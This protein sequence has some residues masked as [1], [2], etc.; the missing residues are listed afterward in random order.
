MYNALTLQDASL[1]DIITDEN[2]EW[3]R[4]LTRLTYPKGKIIFQPG[5]RGESLYLLH[6]GYVRVYRLS[7]DGRE[8]TLGLLGKK[9]VLGELALVSGSWQTAFAEVMEDT[10]ISLLPW[11]AFQEMMRRE[12]EVAYRIMVRMSERLHQAEDLIEDLVNRDVASR[13][14]RILLQLAEQF[15]RASQLGIVIDLRLPYQEIANMVGST[16]ETVTRAI[17]H[18]QQNN[19][20]RLEGGRLHLLDSNA[21]MIL[22]E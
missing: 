4:Q 19:W 11:T 20:V 9:D 22:G 3:A 21:L 15:G 13:V 18:M 17:S 14:A 5:D 1:Y 7:P 12:P 8:V 6:N 16:R 10:E 2:R